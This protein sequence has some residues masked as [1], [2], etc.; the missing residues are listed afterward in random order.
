ML[1][2]YLTSAGIGDNEG[3]LA[4]IVIFILFYFYLYYNLCFEIKKE[5]EINKTQ[6]F[7]KCLFCYGI[8][9]LWHFGI[10]QSASLYMYPY[11]TC[12]PY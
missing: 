11:Y 12:T 3:Y 9:M 8:L 2:Y 4:M 5:C 7:L 1:N 6:L 10:S